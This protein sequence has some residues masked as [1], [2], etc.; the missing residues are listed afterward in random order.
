VWPRHE[1]LVG[2]DPLEF[3]TRCAPHG[4]RGNADRIG[5]NPEGRGACMGTQSVQS[6]AIGGPNKVCL[7]WKVNAVRYAPDVADITGKF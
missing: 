2:S 7:I 1:R 6:A 4:L 5:I 3:C